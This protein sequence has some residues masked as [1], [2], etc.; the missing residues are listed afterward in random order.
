MFT[1]T[2]ATSLDA[3][4]EALIGLVLRRTTPSQISLYVFVHVQEVIVEI[5]SGMAYVRDAFD[6][7][8]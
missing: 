3:G 7:G 8:E 1:C 2:S 5:G 4:I 6:H